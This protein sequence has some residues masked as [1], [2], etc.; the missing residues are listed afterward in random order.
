MA[1]KGK[2]PATHLD[3]V[4]VETREEWRAW[5][6]ANHGQAESIWLVTYKKGA[7][8]P[9]LSYDE[10]VEEALC[11]GWVDSLPR[12]LDDERTMRLLSPRKPKSAWSKVNKE[13][14]AKLEREGLM[15]PAG[16]EKI[17]AAKRDASWSFLDDVETLAM[18]PDL[19]EALTRHPPATENFN[20]FPR[21]AKRG[22]LGWIKLAKRPETRA[23]RVEET[24][25][26]AALNQRANHPQKS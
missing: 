3:R 23:K 25:R 17:A 22:I 14:I 9:Y 7:S 13:R 8:K 15:A 26:L 19:A 16:A 21:S 6:A 18:P 20:A 2:K 11:F 4:T 5:L 10:I 24:A 1:T 12:K